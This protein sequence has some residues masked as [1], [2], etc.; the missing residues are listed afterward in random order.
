MAYRRKPNYHFLT[1]MDKGIYK[2]PNGRMIIVE[3]FNNKVRCFLKISDWN[4]HVNSTILDSIIGGCLGEIALKIG[5]EIEIN[6][7]EVS[8]D[9]RISDGINLKIK[10]D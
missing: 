3:N 4:L 1:E 8:E 5:N 10:G 9:I 7:L 2:V 6:T